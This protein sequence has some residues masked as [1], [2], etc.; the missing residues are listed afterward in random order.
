[1]YIYTGFEPPSVRGVRARAARDHVAHLLRDLESMQLYIDYHHPV[2][3]Y[4]SIHIRV[5]IN[6][7][8]YMYIY[9]YIYIYIYVQLYI[10]MYRYMYMDIHI[11]LHIYR[12]ALCP[13]RPGARRTRACRTPGINIDKRYF[14]ND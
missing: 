8:I 14:S 9:M 5:Y 1:M 6:T 3:V 7:F 2:L 10:Y 4:M 11:H 13:R 12:T